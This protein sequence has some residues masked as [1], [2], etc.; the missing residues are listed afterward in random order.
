MGTALAV[1][2][3]QPSLISILIF[4]FLALGLSSPYLLLS[5]FPKLLRLIPSAGK[6]MESFRQ[7]LGFL[8]MATVIWLVWVLGQLG[9]SIAI[10]LIALLLMSIGGWIY[11]RWGTINHSKKTRV[12]SYIL[13]SS[14]I[15]G[16][17]LYA[18]TEIAKNNNKTN[19]SDSIYENKWETFSPK[20]LKELQNNKTPVFVNFTA[21][22]CL[23][24]QWNSKTV[25]NTKEII[26]KFREYKVVLM[27]ADWTNN[28]P[29]ITKELAK[30]GR[31][32]IPTYALY[33]GK[34]N[35]KPII[36]PEILTKSTVIEALKKIR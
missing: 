6:W 8:L 28:N 14:F 34:K 7:F 3:S 33:T 21:S 12:L 5:F 17:F 13:A 23:S 35:M 31:A 26:K 1:A 19:I 2:L 32:S 16:G 10:M 30:I 4:T 18:R 9:N 25:L 24:C 36:L 15:I 27:E 29:M 22:W 20:K 11:G